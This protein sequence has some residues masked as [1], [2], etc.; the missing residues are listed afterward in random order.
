MRA[1]QQSKE[2]IFHIFVQLAIGDRIVEDRFVD[3]VE[4][5]FVE[6]EKNDA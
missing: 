5:L 1:G 6:I 3:A 2:F 4:L